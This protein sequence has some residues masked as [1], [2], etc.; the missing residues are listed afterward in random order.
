M[1]TN[2]FPLRVTKEILLAMLFQLNMFHFLI[3]Q[4]SKLQVRTSAFNNSFIGIHH[5]SFLNE[6]VTTLAID[7]FCIFSYFSSE[8]IIFVMNSQN[9]S[10]TMNDIRT[11]ITVTIGKQIMSYLLNTRSS[12]SQM[13]FKISVL[14][15]FK[16][17]IGKHLRWSLFLIK[18]RT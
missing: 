7:I 13:F 5:I 12:R 11:Q 10:Y 1:E 9:K 8:N 6:N 15:N 17:F 16:N 14:K 2:C 3:F 18:L 4:G